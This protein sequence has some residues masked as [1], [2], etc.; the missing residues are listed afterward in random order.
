MALAAPVTGEAIERYAYHPYGRVMILDGA[1]ITERTASLFDNPYTFTGRRLDPETG[2]YYY[3]ARYYHPTLGRFLTRDPLGYVDGAG[4]YEYVNAGPL[5]RVDPLGLAQLRSEITFSIET[6]F[7]GQYEDHWT[8]AS[9]A[10]AFGNL[11]GGGK[12]DTVKKSIYQFKEHWRVEH[13]FDAA[14]DADGNLDF[15][16]PKK[17]LLNFD[18]KVRELISLSY[19]NNHGMYKHYIAETGDWKALDS[20]DG[21]WTAPTHWRAVAAPSNKLVCEGKK[22]FLVTIETAF[23]SYALG[24][25]S[26]NTSFTGALGFA[27]GMPPIFG[28]PAMRVGDRVAGVGAVI[29]VG[30]LG[31]AGGRPEADRKPNPAT[32]Q[33]PPGFARRANC[34][35]GCG[36][37]RLSIAMLTH[38]PHA[39]QA[40]PHRKQTHL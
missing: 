4:L 20:R 23:H 2:L 30:P 29:G 25:T 37:S 10:W 5:E 6:S 34:E 3:R 11:V 26:F 14:C 13:R 31:L 35:V 15:M 27:A 12:A 7:E 18:G 16:S 21:T 32:R 40:I 24:G 38:E 33:T 22:G 8:I 1:G 9:Y 36:Y 28:P 17:T 39:N 19:T